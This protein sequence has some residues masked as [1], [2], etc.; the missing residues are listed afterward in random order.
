MSGPVKYLLRIHCNVLQEDDKG[1]SGLNRRESSVGHVNAFGNPRNKYATLANKT[2]IE[3]TYSSG[4]A[5][6]TTLQDVCRDQT[7][8]RRRLHDNRS[9]LH[10]PLPPSLASRI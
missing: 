4:T 8:N 10:I 7:T 1:D 3:C 9:S 6:G 2:H 5:T